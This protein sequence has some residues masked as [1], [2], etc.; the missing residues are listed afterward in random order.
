VEEM[1]PIA[2]AEEALQGARFEL[3]LEWVER[4]RGLLERQEPAGQ[5]PRRRAQLEV[6][7]ATAEIALG[8]EEAARASLRRALRAQPELRLDPARHSP[9]LIRLFEEVRGAD[10]SPP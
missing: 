5:R 9:K 6:L 2:A 3:A 1:E 8:R 10:G 4:G 7:G